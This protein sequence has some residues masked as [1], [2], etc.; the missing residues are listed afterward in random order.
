MHC[1]VK[2]RKRKHVSQRHKEGQHDELWYFMA[3]KKKQ[4]KK[5]T[6]HIKQGHKDYFM[7]FMTE[8]KTYIMLA[9]KI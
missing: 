7:H 5:K 3:K 8:K 1:V 2:W 9:K 4:T 6:R